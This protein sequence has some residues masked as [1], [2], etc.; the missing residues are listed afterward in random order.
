MSVATLQDKKTTLALLGRLLE[1]P[2]KDYASALNEAGV[3]VQRRF[4]SVDSD[5]KAFTSSLSEKELWETEELFTRTFDLAPL[6]CP[7]LSAHLYGDESYDRGGF[8]AQLAA[9]YQEESFDLKGEMPDHLAKVL[10]FAPFF[11]DEELEELAH[12][13]LLKSLDEM[14]SGLESTGNPYLSLLKAIKQAL[15][16][17]LPGRKAHD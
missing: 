14:L 11:S 16:I 1:Y 5:L 4:R 2:T 15:V 6:C 8:M 7:Y 13:C 12:Y 10:Q 17:D 3:F 9:R